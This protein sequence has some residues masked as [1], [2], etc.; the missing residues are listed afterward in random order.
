MVKN[1]TK[2]NNNN[3]ER[4]KCVGGI[5]GDIVG[6]PYEFHPVKEKDVPLIMNASKFSDDSVMTIAVMDWLMG[7]D[8]VES[9]QFWGNKYDKAGYGKSFWNWLHQTNPKPYN[10]FGNG[11]GMRVSP[12][13]W[14]FDTLEE[15]LDFAEKSAN[16]TH[17]HPEGVNGAKAI[18]GSIWLARNS[19]TKEQIR[20][21]CTE[22][23]GYDMGRTVDHIRPDYRFEVSCQKS[24]PEAIICFLDGTSYED[25]VRNAISLG[26]DSDTQACMAGAIAEA[27]GYEIPDNLYDMMLKKITPDMKVVIDVFNEKLK[28]K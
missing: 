28:I 1:I 10:S 11:S 18:A 25:V 7:R 13:G 23:F 22:T 3:M 24:V 9:M 14:M 2:L 8:I 4:L 26:G 27:F 21:F 6:K 16:P 15:T 19:A 20:T 5:V 17:N 12:V